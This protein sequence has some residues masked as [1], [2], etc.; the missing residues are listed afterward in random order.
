M[1]FYYPVNACQYIHTH[2]IIEGDPGEADVYC[3]SSALHITQFR[4]EKFTPRKAA[5]RSYNIGYNSVWPLWP[6]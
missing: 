5:A 2:M 4:Q 3:V 1:F 6:S